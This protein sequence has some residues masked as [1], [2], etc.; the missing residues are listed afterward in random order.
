MPDAQG[1]EQLIRLVRAF[2][3]P[4]RIPTPDDI[5]HA[6]D[7]VQSLTEPNPN[8]FPEV[9]DEDFDRCRQDFRDRF[10][11]R[12]TIGQVLTDCASDPWL[13]DARGEPRTRGTPVVGYHS[14][15]TTSSSFFFSA[16]WLMFHCLRAWGGHAPRTV[17]PYDGSGWAEEGPG[18]VILGVGEGCSSVLG[19]GLAEALGE[20]VTVTINGVG[21]TVLAAGV[22]VTVSVTVGAGA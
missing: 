13:E 21:V 1:K 20:A 14:S 7:T 12:I 4:N 11:I 5:D 8:L 2:L 17:P 16:K 18:T 6:I 19:V 10:S 9:T 22:R 3:P 15:Q